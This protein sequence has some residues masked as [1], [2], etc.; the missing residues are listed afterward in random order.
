MWLNENGVE[1]TGPGDQQQAVDEKISALNEQFGYIN[2]E[3][4][5]KQIAQ[6]HDNNDIT[7]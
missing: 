3:E 5:H 6:I 2:A 4:Q 1:G 7:S